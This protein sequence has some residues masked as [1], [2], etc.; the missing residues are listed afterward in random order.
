MWISLISAPWDARP[1]PS[2]RRRRRPWRRGPTPGRR[3]RARRRSARRRAAWPSTPRPADRTGAGRADVTEDFDDFDLAVE[4][5]PRFAA[6]DGDVIAL[7]QARDRSRRRALLRGGVGR[8]VRCRRRR[9]AAARRGGGLRGGSSALAGMARRRAVGVALARRF[10][11]AAGGKGEE[12]QGEQ[13]ASGSWVGSLRR[14]AWRWAGELRGRWSGACCDQRVAMRSMSSSDRPIT[15]YLPSTTSVGV[16]SSWMRSEKS[17][18]AACARRPRARKRGGELL[19]HRRRGWRNTRRARRRWDFIGITARRAMRGTWRRACA[20]ERA[21]LLGG[22]EGAAERV[23][24]VVAGG[25]VTQHVLRQRGAA[26]R[27][28]WARGRGSGGRYRRRLRRL[29][30]RPCTAANAGRFEHFVI[31][32]FRPASRCANASNGSSRQ[33][34]E[35]E[36]RVMWAASIAGLRRIVKK[37]RSTSVDRRADQ[38][39]ER[40]DSSRRRRFPFLRGRVAELCREYAAGTLDAASPDY[41]CAV[42]ASSERLCRPCT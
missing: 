36:A 25:H 2:L 13:D 9:S 16:P 21:E 5:L 11:L 28:A 23:V 26:R 14:D 4:R 42:L 19:P 30:S 41:C 7:D 22:E 8:G 6:L 12:Q 20:A 38:G 18:A 15:R 31:R 40:F 27:R 39:R 10:G 37:R 3:A 24:H 29:R 32:R 1:G 35:R 33:Q 34:E 17:R